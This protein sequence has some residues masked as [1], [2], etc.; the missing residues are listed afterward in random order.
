M[1]QVN[2]WTEENGL[3][4]AVLILVTDKQVFTPPAIV[5]EGQ[6]VPWSESHRYLGLQVEEDKKYIA[7]TSAKASSST[8][9]STQQA[10]YLKR[11]GTTIRPHQEEMDERKMHAAEIFHKEMKQ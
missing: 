7:L 9:S 8:Q 4:M 1:R 10:S 6:T 3:A 5:L 11:Q 2:N